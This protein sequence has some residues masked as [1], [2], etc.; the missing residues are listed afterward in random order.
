LRVRVAAQ[1]D[2][3]GADRLDAG[4]QVEERALAA[5]GWPDDRDEVARVGGQRDVA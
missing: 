4:D 1:R 2:L 3:A 5:A